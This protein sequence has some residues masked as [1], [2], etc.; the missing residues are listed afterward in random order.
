MA[1]TLYDNIVKVVAYYLGPAASR[2]VDRQIT[3]HLHKSPQEVTAED[4]QGLTEWMRVSLALLTDDRETVE[5]CARKLIQL[6]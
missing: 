5:E 6:A 2:F 3:F 1:E 4:L